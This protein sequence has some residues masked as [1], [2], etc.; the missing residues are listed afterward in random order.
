MIGSGCEVRG[1]YLGWLR[2]L[3]WMTGLYTENAGDVLVA[4]AWGGECETPLRI[5][6]KIHISLT[7]KGGKVEVT[8]AVS[9]IKIGFR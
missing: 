5:R 1:R 3:A 8:V 4:E 9:D 6:L 7:P 2:V